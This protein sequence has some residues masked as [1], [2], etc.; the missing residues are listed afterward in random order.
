MSEPV[1]FEKSMLALEDIVK[2]LERGELPLE[3]SLAQ[4]EKGV[5]LARQCQEALTQAEQKIEQLR[6]NTAALCENEDG[7]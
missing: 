6:I 7:F 2:L 3:E 1:N 5:H 4:Y